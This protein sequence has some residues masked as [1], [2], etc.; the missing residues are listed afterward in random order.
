MPLTVVEFPKTDLRDVAAGMRRIAD[1]IDA[2]EYAGC[3][4]AWVLRGEDGKTRVGMLGE[5]GDPEAA[6]HLL[7]AR[8]M[9]YCE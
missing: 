1:R 3:K 8:G 5:C 9:R 4:M 6:I 2:G 7:L